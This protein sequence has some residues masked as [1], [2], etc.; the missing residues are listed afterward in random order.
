MSK[1]DNA[2]PEKE[3]QE[4]PRTPADT[5][6]EAVQPAA[7]ETAETA[8]PETDL[9]EAEETFTLTRAEME[10]LEG[11]AKELEAQKD[12]YLRLAAEYDNF[13][14]RT[15]KE[16]ESLYGSARIDTVTAL[17][18]VFDNL[19]RGIAGL[20]EGDIHRQG[21]EMILKQFRE[22]LQK[23]GVTEMDCLGQPFDPARMNAVMHIED[24]SLGENTVAE[25]LQRGFTLGGKIL[26]F[27]MVKVAN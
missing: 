27:A 6:K 21:L 25:V 26:R 11:L 20:E 18:P 4:L 3:N 15:A 19:E 23:L 5:E 24:E 22:S 14:K 1:K 10:K 17:L 2:A 16:R 13:R 9:P 8:A 7:G 12:Q